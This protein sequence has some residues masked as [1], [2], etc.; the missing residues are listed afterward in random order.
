MGDDAPNTEHIANEI[1]YRHLLEHVHDAVVEFE[2]VH[3]EPIIRDTNEA[4]VD[5]FGYDPD[6]L[7][8]ESLNEW[9]VPEWRRSESRRFDE[10]TAAGEVTSQQVE[11]KTAHGLREFLYRGIPYDHPDIGMDGLAIYTDL[12]DITRQKRQLQVMNRL[13]RH[14]LRNTVNVISG[15][16]SRLIDE[17]DERTEERAEI[18]AA[19][20][21]AIEDLETLT[22]D[23]NDIN[24]VLNA[25]TEDPVI[26]CVPLVRHVASAYSRRY[27]DA[28]VRTTLPASMSVCAD[29]RLRFAV[30]SLVDNAIRHNPSDGPTVQLRIATGSPGWVDIY[31]DD[32][33]PRIPDEERNIITDDAEITPLRHGSGLGLWLTKWTTELFGGKLSFATSELGGNSVR[34]RIPRA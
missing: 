12:T 17:F 4:F 23:A 27:P 2:L 14:N 13:L 28:T 26:D 20:E 25:T 1:R 9:I 19:V 6:E 15:A 7:Q 32:D 29:R 10:R 16:T 24:T 31:V 5:V 11:R 33:A 21:D 8:G 30:E 3:G 18:V 34:I 22:R